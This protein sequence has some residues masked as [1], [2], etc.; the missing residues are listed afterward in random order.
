MNRGLNFAFSA[1]FFKEDAPWN[2]GMCRFLFFGIILFLYLDKD[3]SQWAKVPEVLWHP[4]FIF[5][6]LSVPVFSVDVLSFLGTLWLTSLFLSS[7]GFLSRPS[8]VCAFVLG[9]YLLGMQNSFAKTHHTESLLLI[10]LCILCF[11]RCGDG[12]SLDAALR[13]RYGWWPVAYAARETE[14]GVPMACEAHMGNVHLGF[15]RS[16]NLKTK[17]LRS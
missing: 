14:R 3:F 1:F 2:L 9:F 17:K 13:R 6:F 5:D 11:S 16:W 4:I 10:I 8:A 12:F 15:L 7:I